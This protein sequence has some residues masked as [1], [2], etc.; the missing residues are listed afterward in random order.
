MSIHVVHIEDDRMLRNILRTSFQIAAPEVQLKQYT[1]GDDA[2][3]YIEQNVKTIDLFIIDIRLPGS[4]NGLQLAQKIRELGCPNHLV[5][6][7]AYTAPNA[8][9]LVALSCDYLPKPW[10]ILDLMQKLVQ[11]QLVPR[12]N[13]NSIK[14]MHLDYQRQ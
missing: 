5:L 2:L 6:T 7:S 12:I 14:P 13:H 11:Y 9:W 10:H 3:P 1:N 8:E 4:I